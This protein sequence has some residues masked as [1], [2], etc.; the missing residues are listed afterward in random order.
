MKI[1]NI[2]QFGLNIFFYLTQNQ[3]FDYHYEHNVLLT[4]LNFVENGNELIKHIGCMLQ[5]ER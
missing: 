3:H 5:K 2:C 1:I 4:M